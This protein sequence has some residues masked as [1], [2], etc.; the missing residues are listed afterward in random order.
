MSK[1]CSPLKKMDILRNSQQLGLGS[2]LQMKKTI[3]F[4]EPEDSKLQVTEPFQFIG[5]SPITLDSH[6]NL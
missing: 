6:H 1:D 2:V 3:I 4:D 5:E